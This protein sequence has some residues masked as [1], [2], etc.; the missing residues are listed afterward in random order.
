M[1][2]AQRFFESQATWDE[3]HTQ[4]SIEYLVERPGDHAGALADLEADLDD[5]QAIELWQVQHAA[6]IAEFKVDPDQAYRWWR[7]VYFAAAKRRIRPPSGVDLAYEA[8]F[9]RPR[10]NP[11]RWDVTVGRPSRHRAPWQF[12]D[13]EAETAAAAIERVRRKLEGEQYPE[14]RSI[15]MAAVPAS[16]AAPWMPEMPNPL[17]RNPSGSPRADAAE[18]YKTFHRYDPKQVVEV[19]GLAIPKRVRRMGKAKWVTYRSGK[20]DPATLEKPRHPVDYIHEH[21]A[22]V[23][24]YMTDD[25][26]DT[27]VPK[28][29]AGSDALVRLGYN[30]GFCFEDDDGEKV[31]AEGTDPLPE[32]YCS[33]DGNCLLVIQGRRKVLAMMWGGALGVFGRGIDG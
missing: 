7:E 32:L 14:A 33:A 2:E 5:P 6:D 4:A 13:V 24:T 29:F 1:S 27:E 23:V 16:G 21:D 19:A 18:L 12:L 15:P 26:A 3:S 20:V 22:G 17:T 9:Q 8:Q 31:E 28:Q 25:K 30:L 11:P 10:R